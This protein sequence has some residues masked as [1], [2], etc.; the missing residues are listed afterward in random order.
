MTHPLLA[1]LNEDQRGS[2]VILVV[3]IEERAVAR[4]ADDHFIA[5]HAKRISDQAARTHK[6]SHQ[7]TT[8]ACT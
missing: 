7:H 4:L 1:V 5:N 2:E 3:S 6:S 8:T